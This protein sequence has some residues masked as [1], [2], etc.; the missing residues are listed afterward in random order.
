M[1]YVAPMLDR[2]KTSSSQGSFARLLAR[3]GRLALTLVYLTLVMTLDLHH[4]HGADGRGGT[5]SLG[6][7]HAESP[8]PVLIFQQAHGDAGCEP[9]QP[10]NLGLCAALSELAPGS[11]ALPH[12]FTPPARGPPSHLFIAA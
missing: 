3:S 2:A 12:T 5:A 7:A 8:C 11:P 1:L 6:L 10:Q 4:N 9:V